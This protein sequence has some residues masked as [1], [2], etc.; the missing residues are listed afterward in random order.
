MTI[1]RACV[2][3]R[4]PGRCWGSLLLLVIFIIINTVL[5]V[6]LLLLDTCL[7]SVGREG[8]EAGGGQQTQN[9]QSWKWLP[10]VKFYRL[11]ERN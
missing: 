9:G 1:F 3:H 6:L 4:K 2:A 7:L 5:V 10:T 8:C 11:D